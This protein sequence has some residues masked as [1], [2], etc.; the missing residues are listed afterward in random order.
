VAKKA[1]PE[2]SITHQRSRRTVEPLFARQEIEMNHL[3]SKP[4]TSIVQRLAA[5]AHLQSVD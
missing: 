3:E 4:K 1:P 5:S 2:R